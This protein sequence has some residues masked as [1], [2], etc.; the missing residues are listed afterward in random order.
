MAFTNY[1][2][3]SAEHSRFVHSLGVLHVATEIF[4]K[5][6]EKHQDILIT[7]D[8]NKEDLVKYLRY[9]ALLHDIGHLPYSHSSE[10]ALL[11][12]EKKHEQLS[13]YIIKNND[14]IRG[15]L[16]SEGLNLEIITE[17]IKGGYIPQ[18]YNIIKRIIS[19]EF[20]ADRTDYLL[21]DSY[22]C[23]VEY[24]RFDYHR[25]IDSFFLYKDSK[26]SDIET[27]IKKKNIH[28]VEAMVMARY[29]YYTQV[30]FHRT[31]IG[32]DKIF[33]LYLNEN[34]EEETSILLDDEIDLDFWNSFDDNYVFERIK[35]DSNKGNIFADI[36]MRVKHLK[37]VYQIGSHAEDN[38]ERD[39]KNISYNL[40]Q[41]GFERDKDFFVEKREKQIHKLDLFSDEKEDSQ[42][43]DHK[44]FDTTEGEILGNLTDESSFLSRFTDPIRI[45]IIYAIPEKFDEI[46]DQVNKIRE[47]LNK[48]DNEKI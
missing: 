28:S 25:F 39:I 12:G 17:I 27:F 33:E 19:G 21:R 22:F 35:E 3:P 13:A 37:P 20:D 6:F 32:Y 40:K 11:K 2:Y 18:G 48:I 1:V 23:G 47:E 30:V 15:V 41:R 42:V 5:L 10:T 4:S 14:T 9:S 24:G 46:K 43:D 26:E 16:E 34:F 31:R 45:F 36:L 38:D 8:L 29:K 7:N 44:V